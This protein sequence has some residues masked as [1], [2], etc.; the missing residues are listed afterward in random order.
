MSMKVVQRLLSLRRRPENRDMY[1]SL[2]YRS[3]CALESGAALSIGCK[4]SLSVSSN[5]LARSAMSGSPNLWKINFY[6]WRSVPDD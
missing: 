2:R 3:V 6:E 4:S 5:S 1:Q